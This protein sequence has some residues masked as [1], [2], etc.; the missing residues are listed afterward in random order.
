MRGRDRSAPP[1][2]PDLPAHRARGPGDADDGDDGHDPDDDPGDASDSG[3]GDPGADDIEQRIDVHAEMLTNRLRKRARHLR[4]WAAREQVSCYRLYDRDIPEVPLIVDWYDGRLYLA[5]YERRREYSLTWL[6]AMATAAGA[7]LGVPEPSIYLKERRRQRGAAQ[8][9]PMDRSGE[10]FIVRE[11]Q[12]RLWVNLRDYL[13]TGLFLDHRDTRLRV[14]REARGGRFLNLFCYTAAFTVHAAVGGAVE[15][16][17]VDLSHTYLDWAHDNMT[18]NGMDGP[19]HRFVRDDVFAYL[20]SARPGFDLAV[21]DPPTF[22][23]SKMMD[24]VLDVQRDHVQLINGTLAL[25]RPGGVLYFSTGFRRFK[26]DDASIRTRTI[27]DITE[28]TTPEDF[29]GQRPHRC[30]RLVK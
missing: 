22:S 8:Y 1:G 9:E 19:A 15:T 28:Q 30:W 5:R 6:E 11:G 7:A 12:C 21:L 27:D 24:D 18:L 14:A 4:K 2:R 20:R 17:S 13:D 3:S 23:N 29:R 26:L 10:R 16:E 25:L